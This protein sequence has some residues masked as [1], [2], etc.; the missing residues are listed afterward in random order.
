MASAPGPNS[1]HLYGAQGN[2]YSGRL[3]DLLSH[4]H[5]AS[6]S[7]VPA[8]SGKTKVFQV[9]FI[10][11][12]SL[13]CTPRITEPLPCTLKYAPIS[14]YF[15]IH[16]KCPTPILGKD[17]FSKFKASV[18][19]PSPPSDLAWLLHFNTH[20]LWHSST[21]T[22]SFLFFQ[23][24]LYEQFSPLTRNCTEECHTSVITLHISPSF[25]A[26]LSTTSQE[27]QDL[28]YVSQRLPSGYGANTSLTGATLA[29]SLSVSETT[30]KFPE[31][32][33]FT[34][35]FSCCLLTPGIFFLC[36]T[37]TCLCLPT[38]WTGIC[39]LV[40]LAPDISIAPN[41]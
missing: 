7:A 4:Q 11:V 18:T 8:Y 20:H 6:H 23:T 30:H 34:I 16:P 5:G 35:D 13:I 39:I 32:L 3:A 26:N 10:G 24:K 2:S 15:L 33:L 41:N 14:H 1:Y 9:S 28:S 25:Q 38:N 40:Y 36:K 29:S 19:I 22:G 27:V 31:R 12:D 17:I 37:T 21:T